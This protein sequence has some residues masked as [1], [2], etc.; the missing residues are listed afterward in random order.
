MLRTKREI[1]PSC[2]NAPNALLLL[3]LWLQA[4][5]VGS[6][7][8]FSLVVARTDSYSQQPRQVLT[9]TAEELSL[10]DSLTCHGVTYRLGDRRWLGPLP[11]EDITDTENQDRSISIKFLLSSRFKRPI[12]TFESALIAHLIR[13]F[14]YYDNELGCKYWETANEK[15]RKGV[16]GGKVPCVPVGVQGGLEEEAGQQS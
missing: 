9:Y 12:S 6:S 10:G 11:S 15:K 4:L 1:T 8:C 13:L 14:L 16:L 5:E 7:R 2:H 3:Q